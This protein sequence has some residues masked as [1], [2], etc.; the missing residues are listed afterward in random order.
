M[1]EWHALTNERLTQ[2]MWELH[3]KVRELQEQVGGLQ[4]KIDQYE[5]NIDDIH[6]EV[7]TAHEKIKAIAHRT[8][9]REGEREIAP[10]S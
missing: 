4:D 2:L 9:V 1:S 5:E 6:S 3:D 8:G 10:D 7:M